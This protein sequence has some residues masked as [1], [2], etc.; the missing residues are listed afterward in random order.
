MGKPQL[1][2]LKVLETENCRSKKIVVDLELDKLILKENLDSLKPQP[3]GRR[4]SPSGNPRS[5]ET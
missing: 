5:S 1:S 2:E 3:D 4:L